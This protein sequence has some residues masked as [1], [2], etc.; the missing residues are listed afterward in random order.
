MTIYNAEQLNE[1][2][3]KETTRFVVEAEFV[4]ETVGGQPGGD[5]GL[6]AYV[7]HHLGLKGDEAEAAMSRIRKSELDVTPDG[8]EIAEKQLYSLN[9]IRKDANGHWL[10]DWMVKA[11]FKAAASRLGLFVSTKGL[12]GNIAEMGRIQASGHSAKGEPFHIYLT[13]QDGGPVQTFYQEFK[14]R[15]SGP[16]GSNS[17]VTTSE[18]APAG[19]KF[20]FEFRFKTTPKFGTEDIARVVAAMQVIGL[21][22]AKSLERGKFRVTKLAIG[23]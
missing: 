8:G 5:D 19:T 4:R 6:R 11:C 23:E 14:G 13:D 10:G 3:E 7:E 2:Y 21:G 16:S 12:K 22:S 20:S 18:C 15:V 17:I 9:N 1:L